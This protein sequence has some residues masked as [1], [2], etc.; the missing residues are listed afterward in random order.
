MNVVSL[1]KHANASRRDEETFA[2][3][4]GSAVTNAV[5]DILA[6]ASFRYKLNNSKLLFD[7]IENSCLR[8]ETFVEIAEGPLSSN[9]MNDFLTVACFRYKQVW[10]K[11]KL[12]Q[13]LNIR[14]FNVYFNVLWTLAILA[15]YVITKEYYGIKMTKKYSGFRFELTGHVHGVGTL[16]AIQAKTDELACFGCWKQHNSQTKITGEVRCTRRDGK[17]L[18]EFLISKDFHPDKS[19]VTGIEMNNYNDT[20]IELQ[21]LDFE[22]FDE[23]RETCFRDS[24]HQC[25]EVMNGSS[26]Y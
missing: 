13:K 3:P 25:N 21:L 12:N 24:P 11:S 1:D 14:S 23:R 9:A 10:R 20:K 15:L 7:K 2:I 19:F 6:V 17:K 26:F 18:K 5:N 16:N 4:V 22:M 8:E